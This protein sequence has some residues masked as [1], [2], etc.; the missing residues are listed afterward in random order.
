MIDGKDEK[1]EKDEMWKMI[2]FEKWQSLSI[3]SVLC[4]DQQ[5]LDQYHQCHHQHRHQEVVG[6]GERE[7]REWPGYRGRQYR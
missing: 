5:H 1:D 3:D 4:V 6:C 2:R 7:N